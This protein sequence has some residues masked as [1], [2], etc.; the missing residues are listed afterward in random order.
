[1][2]KV[3]VPFNTDLKAYYAVFSKTN[4]GEYVQCT[5]EHRDLHTCV[6]LWRD[7]ELNNSDETYKIYQVLISQI[8]V[9]K[10]S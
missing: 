6:E 5:T 7:L 2:N 4:N 1:M 9:P 10:E 3:T 8:Y